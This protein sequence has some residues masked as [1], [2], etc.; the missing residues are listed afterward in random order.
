MEIRL[1]N[2]SERYKSRQES[3]TLSK[4]GRRIFAWEGKNLVYPSNVLHKPPALSQ[5]RA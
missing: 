3:A 5:H 1:K 4:V 2:M